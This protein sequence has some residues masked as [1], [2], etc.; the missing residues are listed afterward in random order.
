M[1]DPGSWW[2]APRFNVK[3][4]RRS[5]SAR[6]ERNGGYFVLALLSPRLYWIRIEAAGYQAQDAHRVDLPVAG[7]LESRFGL[8]LL[9]D[10]W[11]AGKYRC[12]FLPNNS[13]VLTFFGPDV[14]TSH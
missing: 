13:A 10:A 5:G 7:R 9:D 12:I 4:Y 2:H 1:H 11:E 14:D 8:R 6:T 3:V